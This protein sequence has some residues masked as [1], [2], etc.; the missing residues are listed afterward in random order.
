M[1]Q[2]VVEVIQVTAL[3]IS[4]LQGVDLS[5]RFIEGRVEPS[6]QFRHGEISFGV[7][8]VYSGVYQPG[9]AVRT[10]DEVTGPKITM[11]ERGER[12]FYKMIFKV[13]EKIKGKQITPILLVKDNLAS[14]I[15]LVYI[16]RADRV[17]PVSQTKTIR[18][19]PDRLF[20]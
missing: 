10:G 7:A 5:I 2:Q 18:F 6:K 9:F 17:E 20:S 15:C 3:F 14:N 1:V 19:A 13:I 16:R 11:E 4:R 12:E 8:D